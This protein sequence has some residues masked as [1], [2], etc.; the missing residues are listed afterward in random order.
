MGRKR[1]GKRERTTRNPQEMA[2]AFRANVARRTAVPVA[3]GASVVAFA[4]KGR[5]PK[6]DAKGDAVTGKDTSSPRTGTRSARRPRSSVPPTTASPTRSAT[7]GKRL[8]LPGARCAS[9]H[10]RLDLG[11]DLYEPSGLIHNKFDFYCSEGARPGAL[12]LI[13]AY[14][15]AKK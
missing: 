7:T 6:D 9:T 5:P 11:A 1:A 3:R 14:R 12:F 8:L 13:A 2:P 4:G 10:R 15:P